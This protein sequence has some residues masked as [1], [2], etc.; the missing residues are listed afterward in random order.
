MKSKMNLKGNFVEI[1]SKPIWDCE[2]WIMLM[3]KWIILQRRHVVIGH[4][5]LVVSDGRLVDMKIVS[6]KKIKT[7]ENV[8][9]FNFFLKNRKH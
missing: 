6:K 3:E 1:T 8:H 2:R 4:A 7:S 5:Y 9:Y